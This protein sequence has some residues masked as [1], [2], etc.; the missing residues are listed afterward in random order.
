MSL[1][2]LDLS[3]ALSKWSGGTRSAAEVSE[4]LSAAVLGEREQL[5]ELGIAISEADVQARL[6]KKG[7]DDLKGAA[8]AQ[9]EAVA[10]QELIYEKSTDAQKA[11]A[12]GGKQAA[13]AQHALSSAIGEAKEKLITALTPAIQT[14]IGWL[15]KNLVPAIQEVATWLSVHL[16]AAIDA[17]AT[18]LRTR[19]VSAL[20]DAQ[21]WWQNNKTIVGELANALSVLL[22]PATN[23]ATESTKQA[24]TASGGLKGSLDRLTIV[25]LR[26]AQGFLFVDYTLTG[27]IAGL[28]TTGIIAGKLFNILGISRHAADSFIKDMQ[29]MKDGAVRRMEEIQRE[30]DQL[31]GAID[32]LH[33]KDIHFT[34]NIGELRRGIQA[35]KHNTFVGLQHG[36]SSW[37]GGPAIVGERGP[38]LVDLPRGARVTPNS[39]LAG[40]GG[41]VVLEIRSGGSRLDDLLVEILRK[42]IRSRGGDVQIVLGT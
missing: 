32:S 8:L 7:Q 18:W 42:S 33:G 23:N 30:A 39:A 15:S 40:A 37:R 35:L 14:A 19:L 3:G 9:A 17:T 1:K 20:Q 38:E 13:E 16:P 22:I 24:A 27:V 36:T 29:R 31:Q 41:R 2:F 11:W 12:E 25:L 21:V 5:K 28:A 34:S 26:A 4:I 6:A 10:T